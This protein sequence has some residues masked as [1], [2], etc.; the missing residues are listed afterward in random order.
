MVSKPKGRKFYVVKF[1]EQGKTVQVRTRATTRKHAEKIE[2]QIHVA[3]ENGNWGI[4]ERQPAPKLS[5]FLKADF[6]PFVRT[7]HE[8]KRNTLD[9]YEYG[10]KQLLASEIASLTLDQITSQNVNLYV[11][12]HGHFEKSTVNRDL[13][14]LRR[15]LSLAV[16]WGKLSKAPKVEL[17]KGENR[18]ERVVSDAE[19]D[20]YLEACPQPWKDVAT[21]ILGTGMRPGEAYC[22]DWRNVL[23][24]G[25]GGLIQITQ[26]KTRAARRL[27]LMVPRVYEA[28]KARHESQGRPFEGWVFPTGSASGHIEE[29]SAKQWH[30]KAFEIL[31]AARKENPDLPELKY[32]EPYCLRH[33]ALTN[34]E[35]AGCDAYTLARIAGHTSIR[36]TERYV[37][38]QAEAIERAF[39]KMAEGQGVVTTG[40]Y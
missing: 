25:S 27:L 26:G 28:L 33:T 17:A 37:H 31:E 34:L 40:G 5:E 21:L 15:A 8:T 4:L 18:R 35:A 36:M 29:S 16:E 22:L 12:Q 20:R 9:Y 14:C 24:N 32:F 39:Q 38:P 6:L 10:T 7:Q 30:E 13:R 19:A 1:Q 3:L 23:L 11:A 2:R